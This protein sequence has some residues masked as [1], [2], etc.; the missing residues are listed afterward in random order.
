MLTLQYKS[1]QLTMA[2]KWCIRRNLFKRS[3]SSSEPVLIPDKRTQNRSTSKS[4]RF[5]SNGI[6]L[7]NGCTRHLSWFQAIQVDTK[8]IFCS[9]PTDGDASDETD[10]E[11]DDTFESLPKDFY[12]GN[13]G[14]RNIGQINVSSLR[15]DTVASKA[16]GLSK[17]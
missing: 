17:K 2:L 6:P 7:Y 10:W 12:E 3:V 11:D 8:R 14:D 9:K 1:T 4:I 13:A 5:Y 15:L 16:F